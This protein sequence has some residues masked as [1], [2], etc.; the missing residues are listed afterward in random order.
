MHGHPFG[1][2]EKYNVIA[3]KLMNAIFCNVRENDG[4]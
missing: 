3:I 2:S 1:M 4:S